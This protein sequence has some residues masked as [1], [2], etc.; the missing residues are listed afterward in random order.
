MSFRRLNSALSIKVLGDKCFG[1]YDSVRV[2][3]HLTSFALL[4]YKYVPWGKKLVG[5]E[6]RRFFLNILKP[7]PKIPFLFN[8]II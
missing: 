5:M 4:L 2:A 6:K 1:T 8:S 3:P 7:I